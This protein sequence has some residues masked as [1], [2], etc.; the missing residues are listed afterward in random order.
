MSDLSKWICDD[1]II[2]INNKKNRLIEHRKCHF[3]L[4]GSE[5]WMDQSMLEVDQD[6]YL[7]VP[8][9]KINPAE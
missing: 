1:A 4:N 5:P 7:N 6:F 3:R 8:A 9:R 2:P